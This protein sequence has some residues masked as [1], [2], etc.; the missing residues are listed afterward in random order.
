LL[1][2]MVHAAELRQEL[3]NQ[4]GAEDFA[5]PT[6]RALAT[7]LLGAASA[8]SD[9]LRSALNDEA[10][11]RL[12]LSLVFED[13]PVEE[14]DREKVVNE[15][16]EFLVR[17][18]T[19]GRFEALSAAITTAQAAGDIQQVRRLQAEYEELIGVMHAS[20]K[21]GDDDG[22]EKGGA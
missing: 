7:A 18:R 15:S 1:H 13:P 14:K 2:L 22:Q 20:R 6:H 11:E 4:V 9:V 5:D 17:Q 10:A 12:L 16:V 19:A 21:G 3:A 8:D